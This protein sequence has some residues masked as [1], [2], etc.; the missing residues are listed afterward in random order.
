[1][2][3]GVRTQEEPAEK[4]QCKGK[5]RRRVLGEGH[6]HLLEGTRSGVRVS[7]AVSPTPPAGLPLP[8]APCFM[9]P[10]GILP[11]ETVSLFQL[12][13]LGSFLQTSPRPACTT[14]EGSSPSVAVQRLHQPGAPSHRRDCRGAQGTYQGHGL[15]LQ[16]QPLGDNLGTGGKC[17]FSGPSW[18]ATESGS[19]QWSPEARDH[20]PLGQ[21]NAHGSL[22]TTSP[23]GASGLQG[24]RCRHSQR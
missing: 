24:Q 1:M 21:C 12:T 19:L 6:G 10:E 20:K 2:G 8:A 4:G 3:G 5:A 18:K 22:R 7:R 23:Q 17:K 9:C 16:S 15:H 11:V 14:T 13:P